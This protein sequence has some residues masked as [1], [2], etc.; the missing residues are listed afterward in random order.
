[1]R[2]CSALVM[3]C[4]LLAA[5]VALAA[6][7]DAPAAAVAPDWL[8]AKIGGLTPEQRTFLLS[9]EAD[10]FAG[11][12]ERLY[13][14]LRD[15]SPEQVAAYVEGMM[16]VVAAEKFDP[17]TD[18]ASIPLNTESPEFNAWKVRRPASLGPQREPGPIPLNYYA[19]GR[20]GIRTFA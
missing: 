11:T 4:V 12:R 16:S 13:Q 7:D 2:H 17:Q 14:R 6:A 10:R 19:N 5:P 20:G 3:G 18:M 8:E 9:E 15:K 1:M